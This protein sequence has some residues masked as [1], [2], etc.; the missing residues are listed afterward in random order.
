M[1]LK[2]KISNSIEKNLQRLDIS[3]TE[4]ETLV[5]EAKTSIEEIMTLAKNVLKPENQQ[6]TE[7][8]FS[9]IYKSMCIYQDTE[10]I[11]NKFGE[12]LYEEFSKNRRNYILK[13]KDSIGK[14]LTEVQKEL[15]DQI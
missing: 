12:T 14:I 4:E 1:D 7:K 3:L 8:E 9:D 2:Y 11:K 5:V 13:Y 10:I 15:S 6:L